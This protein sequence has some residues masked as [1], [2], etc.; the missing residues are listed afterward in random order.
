MAG[1]KVIVVL[2]NAA[3]AAQIRPLLPSAPGTMVIVTS[4]RRINGLDVDPPVSLPLFAPA[5]GVAL[6][7]STA[8]L[9][10]W[11]RSLKRHWR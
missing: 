9:T 10:G 1:R 8:G 4:R 6:L 7:A 5:E 11:R 3:D 2:D